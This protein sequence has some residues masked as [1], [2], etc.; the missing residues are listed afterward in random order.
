MMNIGSLHILKYLSVVVGLLDSLKYY[1]G[2]NQAVFRSSM[3]VL[4]SKE[5]KPIKRVFAL[6]LYL[7]Y[8]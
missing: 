6:R 5:H 4:P 8:A 1:D 7:G 3:R 2:R